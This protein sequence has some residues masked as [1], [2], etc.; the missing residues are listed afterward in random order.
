MPPAYDTQVLISE[1]QIRERIA[2]LGRDI[3]AQH[4]GKR[5]VCVGVL[6]GSFMFLADLVR[7]I[8]LPELE[9]DFIGVSSYQGTQSTGVV[10][11]TTDLARSIEGEDVLLVEDIVDTGLTIRYLLDNLATRR[12]RTLKVA[13]LLEKPARAKVQV[14]V[15]FRGFTIEDRFVVGYGLDYDG[16]LRNLPHVALLHLR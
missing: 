3:A 13:A 10:R 2:E 6:K 7:A 16:R 14:P 11:I 5:L 12:P 8:P 15:D 4:T 9:V 1:A